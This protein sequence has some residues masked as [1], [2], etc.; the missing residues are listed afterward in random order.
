MCTNSI[1]RFSKVRNVK[2]PSRGTLY[3]AGLDFYIPEDFQ[4]TQ[5]Q[6]G[7]DI[8]IPSGIKAAI[9][10]GYMLIAH[11]KSGIA[12][13][14]QALLSAQR[15]PKNASWQSSLIIGAKVI[16]EDY[17]GEIGLHLI[18]V[19]NYPLDLKPGMKIAQFILVPVLYAVP[20]ECSESELFDHKSSRGDGGWGSTGQE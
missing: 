4:A 16:D 8:L 2:S 9:P 6:P 10:N 18:N 3:S 17:Q 7:S 19:G 12:T 5:L 14:A 1:L 11:D 20:R 13:S 15:N